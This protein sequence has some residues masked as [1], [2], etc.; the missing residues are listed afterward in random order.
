[1]S[2]SPIAE[3]PVTPKEAVSPPPLRKRPRDLSTEQACRRALAAWVNDIDV[4]KLDPKKA[5]SMFY[6]LSILIGSFRDER[7]EEIE[8]QIAEL[9]GIGGTK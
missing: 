1:V 5:N 6:G 3:K 2:R 4:G 7:L 8:K 9:R